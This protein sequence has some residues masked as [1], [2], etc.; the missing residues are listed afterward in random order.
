MPEKTFQE[1]I[2]GV[3][4]GSLPA[5]VS[6]QERTLVEPEWFVERGRRVR[7]PGDVPR[8]PPGGIKFTIEN[9]EY[10]WKEDRSLWV[11]DKHIGSLDP[12]TGI[13]ARLTEKETRTDREVRQREIYQ[14][15][16]LAPYTREQMEEPW[17]KEMQKEQAA[18]QM[19]YEEALAFAKPFEESLLGR[20]LELLDAA[21]TTAG[22]IITKPFRPE[23]GQPIEPYPLPFIPG[24]AEHQAYL[25]WKGSS[26]D[27]SLPIGIPSWEQWGGI[28]GLGE[29]PENYEMARMGLAET[30]ELAAFI[31]LT[32]G[33]GAFTKQVLQKAGVIS[34]KTA[35]R[36]VVTK[37]EQKVLQQAARAEMAAFKD[38]APTLAK[39]EKAWRA[40]AKKTVGGFDEGAAT[41]WRTI[42]EKLLDKFAGIN[43]LT[44]RA[45]NQWKKTRP[46]EEFPIVLD[47]EL[48]AAKLGGAAAGGVQRATD[49]WARMKLALGKQIPLRFVD[50]Y[51][52]LKHSLNVLAMHPQRLISG[53]LKGI[54]EVNLGLKEMRS[55]L[56]KEGFARVEAASKEITTHWA[57]YLQMGVDSGLISKKLATLLRKKYPNYNP[58]A[59][60]D[61]IVAEEG[62]GV[63]RAISVTKNDIKLLSDLGRDA[64]RERPLDTLARLSLQKEVLIQ[65]NNA[66]KSL[67][68]LIKYDEQLLKEVKGLPKT[69]RG[70][71]SYMEGGVRHSVVVPKWLEAEAKLLGQMGFGDLERLG[72]VLNA[73]S[74]FGMTTANLAFFIPNM[75]VDT[76]TAMLTYGVGPARIVK[77]LLLNLKDIIREDKVLSEIRRSGG[78]VFGFWGKTPE[79]L[80]DEARKKGML[81]LQNKWDWKRIMAAPFEAITKIGHAVEMTPRSAIYEL[82][83]AR[84]ALLD[85]A[86]LAARR[87]TIDFQR[88][89]TA[90]RQAN[91][92]FLYLNAGVQG[93]MIPFRALRDFPRARIFT[94]GYLGA[95]LGTYAWNRQFPEYEDIPDHYKYGG[96]PVM[97][98]SEEYDRRGNKVPHFILVVP[99]LREWA[100]FSGPIIYALRKLDKQA[101]DDV[102]QFLE[103]W[104]PPLNPVSQIV[105]QGGLPVPT[106]VA[107][108]LT[109]LSMNRDTFRSRDIVPEEL[110]N[111]P[112]AEQYNEWTTLTARKVGEALGFSPM[113][114]DFLSR[115]IFGGLGSQFLSAM[116]GVIGIIEGEGGDPRIQL[117][118][119]QLEGI[120]EN[121]LPEKIPARRRDFLEALSPE[122]REAVLSLEIHPEK[123]I[124]IYSDI[125]RR[126][127]VERGG[128]IFQTAKRIVKEALDND[129]SLET[130]QEELN[131][132]ALQNALN[133]TNGL[134]SGQQYRDILKNARQHFRGRT[135]EAWRLRELAGAIATADVQ[136][137]LPEEYQWKPEERALHNYYL[138]IDMLFTELGGVETDE[139]V[140]LLWRKVDSYINSLSPENKEFVETHKNDWINE[141]PY[142]AQVVQRKYVADMDYLG[143]IGYWDIPT[144]AEQ[145]AQ[146]LKAVDKRGDLRKANPHVDAILAFWFDYVT[147]VKSQEAMDLLI[148][149]ARDMG[150]PYNAIPAIAKITGAEPTTPGLLPYSPERVKGKLA[151]VFGR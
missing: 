12:D 70:S 111:L 73:A 121:S 14:K 110:I 27:P 62:K 112:P 98:P 59:Y 18:V 94:T 74:R 90:I 127:Y 80:A 97:L 4:G 128:Q 108:V 8:F 151:E 7:R 96:F 79:K 113:K 28:L 65:R 3:F 106:Q 99:N 6:T 1:K 37:A 87:G 88:S 48:Y 115:G 123:R 25:K 120:Q 103:A 34:T 104:L 122:D 131:K 26:L 119:D 63:G 95:T 44:T 69:S 78:E 146:G 118:L 105:G 133:F 20:G 53:G 75:A 42:E 134:I 150:R 9:V 66:A 24:G 129:K 116:D 56:G 109:E 36:A 67:A 125:L 61:R 126:V 102:G 23:I 89:G 117:L 40:E 107:Q 130:A 10:T 51:L 149:K 91:A 83:L 2:S 92:L 19:E 144:M 50:D 55:L 49:A 52:H 35:T 136:P 145:R 64:I 32:G 33:I 22:A 135:A 31:V 5:G 16:P 139:N 77:R 60:I 141:L 58:I 148:K 93:T 137:Y 86:I 143:E 142:E 39:V 46:N 100:F 57:N 43:K 17:Y 132:L 68:N 85:Q 72:M 84:G 82:Q 81:V 21:L 138:V 41:F 54:D 147:T 101:P 124:P 140:S 30:T 71:I 38:K 76:L 15:Y 13:F 11:K 29:K 47:A 45:K 114:I